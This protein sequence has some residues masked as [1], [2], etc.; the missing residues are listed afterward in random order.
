MKLNKRPLTIELSNDIYIECKAIG[1]KNGVSAEAICEEF[2]QFALD[3]YR[4]G[5]M[6]ERESGDSVFGQAES[7]TV[8]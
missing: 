8:N 2:V 3:L 6:K 4:D 7:E 5:K 1:D